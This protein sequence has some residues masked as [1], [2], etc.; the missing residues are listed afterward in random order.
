MTLRRKNPTS[1][2]YF[3]K[4]A[5]FTLTFQEMTKVYIL[6]VSLFY[7]TM[8]SMLLL[9]YRLK[10]IRAGSFTQL[11]TMAGLYLGAIPVAL[12]W[13]FLICGLGLAWGAVSFAVVS[14]CVLGRLLRQFPARGVL[15]FVWHLFLLVGDM[16]R[17]GWRVFWVEVAVRCAATVLRLLLSPRVEWVML[18]LSNGLLRVLIFL[19]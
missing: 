12:R 1:S 14:T 9:F 15:L 18:G 7:E 6:A 13:P 4:S 8:L 11:L 3:R 17:V 5:Y 2:F 16:I 10:V 19:E